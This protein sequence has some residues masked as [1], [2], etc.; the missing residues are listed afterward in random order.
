MSDFD[1]TFAAT[2]WPNAL[3]MFGETVIH[4]PTGATAAYNV[5]LICDDSESTL[6]QKGGRARMAV[7]GPVAS[8]TTAPAEGDKF[9][10]ASDGMVLRCMEVDDDKA[11]GYI[12]WCRVESA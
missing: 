11:G 2:Y 12:C 9:T 10:R 7:C 1:S 4:D 5:T 3:T 6:A 8:F